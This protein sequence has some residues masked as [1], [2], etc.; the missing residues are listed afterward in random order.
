MN[1][2]WVMSVLLAAL[3]TGAQDP[4]AKK[5]YAKDGVLW[6]A[7]WKEAYDEA[8]LRNVPIFVAFHKDDSALCLAMADSVYTD[9]TFI[10]AS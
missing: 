9:K 6:A 3:A 7:S 4:A 1:R 2:G 5:E 8:Y 10:E